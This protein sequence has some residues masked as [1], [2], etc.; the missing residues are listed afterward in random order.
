[1]LSA[2]QSLGPVKYAKGHW[3]LLL[4]LPKSVLPPLPKVSAATPTKVCATTPT[5]SLCYHPYQKS[6]LPPLPK[7][8]LPPLPN[9]SATT[10]TAARLCTSGGVWQRLLMLLQISAPLF[11]A[12]LVH[13]DELW[14]WLEQGL[15]LAPA[16]VSVTAA[17]L[18]FVQRWPYAVDR[19]LKSRN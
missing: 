14:H 18:P 6:L 12:L 5:K 1:M 13:A 4:P 10:P 3:S 9:V 15:T 19:T 2:L 16:G 8:L 11:V 7:S 17:D